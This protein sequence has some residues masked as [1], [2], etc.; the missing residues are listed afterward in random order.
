[1]FTGAGFSVGAGIAV[2]TGLAVAVGT[3]V[4]AGIVVDDG[5][6]VAFGVGSGVAVGADVGDAPA[7][8]LGSG[9]AVGVGS[10]W[11]QDNPTTKSANGTKIT[12]LIITW[13]LCPFPK[14]NLASLF[15]T[16]SREKLSHLAPQRHYLAASPV[17]GVPTG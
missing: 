11:A 12:G 15:P 16:P 9:V 14:I 6:E 10:G 5:T 8:G 3:G 2:G 13:L 4:S 1:M 7:E 17:R